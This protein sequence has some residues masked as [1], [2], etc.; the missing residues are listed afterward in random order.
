L[1]EDLRFTEDLRQLAAEACDIARHLCGSCENFHLLWPYLR[2]AK[3]SGGDV[4]EQLFRTA[5]NR[6]LSGSDQKV[7]IAGAADTGLLAV[8][9]RAASSDPGIVVLDRCATPLELCRRFS[10]RWLLP[11]KTLQMDLVALDVRATFDVVVAHSLL[12]FILPDRRVDVL[13]RLR[14]SLRPGGRL[15]IV[16]RT[17]ARIEGSLLREYRETYSKNL[18]ERMEEMNIPLPEQREDFRRRVDE[19]SEERRTREGAHQNRADVEQ[20]IE[21]AGFSIEE[22]TSIEANLSAPFRQF[23]AKID[24][25]RFLMVAK[26]RI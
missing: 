17:S 10:N 15:L 6:M 14:R 19:Y 9:A 1:S 22:L 3:A 7:L 21:T 8:V 4:D 13:S 24:K 11:V 2:L 20:L 18:I 12:Q 26:P 25:Q 5:L 16:F 23:N